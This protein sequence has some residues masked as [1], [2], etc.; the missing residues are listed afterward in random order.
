MRNL[1]IGLVLFFELLFCGIKPAYSVVLPQNNTVEIQEIKQNSQKEI[2]NSK[3]YEHAVLRINNDSEIYTSLIR[4]T[5][6]NGY[7]KISAT[8]DV[9]YVSTNVFINNPI[10]KNH[11]IS[12]NLKNEICTRAP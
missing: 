12:S 2:Y 1:F 10:A 9:Y 11:Y 8:D 6:G 5:F 7:D 3:N 4:E